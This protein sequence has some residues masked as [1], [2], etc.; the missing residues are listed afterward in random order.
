MSRRAPGEPAIGELICELHQDLVRKYKKHGSSIDTFWRS[1]DRN[2]RA[3]CMKAGAA[4]G[5]VLKHP[6]DRSLGN[7][8]KFLPEWNLRD[9]TDP[10]STSL[11]DILK[12]RATHSPSEQYAEGVNG[13]PG[14]HEAIVNSMRT[15][16][17]R[18]IDD[19][20]DCWTFFIDGRY[21]SSFKIVQEKE[22]TLA[23]FAP[24]IEA[25]Y[26]IP[27]SVGELVLQRQMYLLQGLVIMIDDILEEGSKTRKKKPIAKPYDDSGSAAHLA[28]ALGALT[29][30]PSRKLS[31]PD[32]VAMAEDQRAALQERLDLLSIEPIVLAHDVNIC[33]F[34]RP[35]LVP[36]EKGRIMPVHTDKYISAAIFEAVHNAVRNSAIWN[37]LTRLLTILEST[38]DKAYRPIILQELSN[39][40]HLE[41][42]RAQAEFKRQVQTGLG[43]KWFKRMCNVYNKAGD[44]RVVV[45]G[46]PEDLMREDP[47]LHY[48][49]RLCQPETTAAK[50]VDW[51]KK[52]SDLHNSH[53]SELERLTEREYA[54][55][56][57]LAVIVAFI[58]EMSPVI[59]MPSLSRKKGQMFVSRSQDLDAELS[60]VKKNV[61]LLD[62]AVPI[63][64]L[65]E[66]G[67]AEAALKALDDFVVEKAGSELGFLYQDL[68]EDCVLYLEHQL[69]L[70]NAKA[71]K[72]EVPAPSFVIPEK[73]E[74]RVQ[75][76]KEKEKTRPSV[77]STFEIAPPRLE[78]KTSEPTKATSSQIFKVK[79]DTAKVFSTLFA[80]SVARGSVSWTAFTTAM[81][82]IGFSIMPKFGSAFTF[83]PPQSMDVQKPFTIH[84]PHQ[85]HIEGYTVPI[86]ARRLNRAYGWGE[87]TFELA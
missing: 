55:F 38:K 71:P 65:L 3:R 8:Y 43:P 53:P 15:Q 18:H 77:P 75:Q 82:E 14:D 83:F 30:A 54:G 28:S 68:I 66:P 45:K 32:I 31:L 9:I 23:G 61:D 80:K 87:K 42:G 24:A 37:Y 63:D 73:P 85:P 5:V 67:M 1:F 72:T 10:N 79:S 51:V 26:C 16:G 76:R 47:Q 52:L 19:F 57:N 46:N 33:F 39:I 64:N 56:G 11:L 25:G 84:R 6:T 81:A 74:E 13:G 21:G 27:Q 17:L 58:H 62:F 49:L 69:E 78:A 2:Q 70:A 44:A 29:R 35:E 12:H 36:D 86:F 41:Y 40:C 50:A 20:K 48:M 59:S 22:Q 34:S 60:E 4:D 7:V